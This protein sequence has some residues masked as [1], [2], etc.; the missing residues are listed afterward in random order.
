M[1]L[2]RL[3][4]FSRLL[5]AASEAT[6][7]ITVHV[8]D[9]SAAGQHEVAE[10]IRGAAHI[11]EQ[12][13][14]RTGWSYCRVGADPSNAKTGCAGS[15]RG[16]THLIV[17]ILPEHMARRLNARPRVLGMSLTTSSA[18]LPTDAYLFYDRAVKLAAATSTQGPALLGAALAHEVGHLLLGDNS[19]S[20]SG[21]MRDRWV[22][23]D[24]KLLLTGSLLFNRAE[25]NR[26]RIAVIH[27]VSQ[28]VSL[29]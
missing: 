27:R 24:L 6:P 14:V 19:H 10:G 26:L 25:E 17:R 4:F 20:G 22:G 16:R 29:P 8:Y 18:T 5:L 7:E 13:N 12:A 2:L 21:L 1:R 15:A 3:L 9:Y 11:L 23:A 28:S